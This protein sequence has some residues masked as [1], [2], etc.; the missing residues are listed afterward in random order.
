M[1]TLQCQFNDFLRCAAVVKRTSGN[2]QPKSVIRCF[3][4]SHNERAFNFNI[5]QVKD[6][7]DDLESRF[8]VIL[9]VNIR[10]YNP[11]FLICFSNLLF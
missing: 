7:R 10:K 6:I 5:P 2:R 1:C 3:L 8:L 4:I 9:K 11:I